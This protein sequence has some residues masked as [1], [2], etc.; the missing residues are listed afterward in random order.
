MLSSPMSVERDEGGDDDFQRGGGMAVF[1]RS[2]FRPSFL[3]STVHAHPGASRSVL[4]LQ[5]ALGGINDIPSVGGV[6]GFG[7]NSEDQEQEIGVEGY[8]GDDD[9]DKNLLNDQVVTPMSARK[10]SSNGLAER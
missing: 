8:E 3:G 7:P 5:S 9:R 2:T 6:R 10:I 1:S 4:S